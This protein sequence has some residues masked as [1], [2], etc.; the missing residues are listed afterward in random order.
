MME[1]NSPFKR[2]IL[3]KITLLAGFALLAFP[4]D[5]TAQATYA[6]I[7]QLNG[8][9]YQIMRA[10]KATPFQQRYNTL[11]PVIE[12]TFDLDTILQSAV[13]PRWA[14]LPPDQQSALREAFRRYTISTYVSNFDSFSGQRFEILPGTRPVGSDQI[15]QT[16]IV[17]TSGEVHILDY[18]M[19]SAGGSW[20]VVD[21]LADGSI[22]RVA[23]QRS[24]I[25]SVFGT[26]GG[27]ALLNRLQTKTA[28]LSG[29]QVR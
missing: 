29:G 8:A 4:M 14:T 1:T 24:E 12:R 18:L 2:R 25:R 17:P 19:R 26:G 15:V 11:A 7:E 10:G 16:R 22:S 13:G 3:L 23:A 21:V 6:P 9:L 27:P 28:E 5:A 20:K